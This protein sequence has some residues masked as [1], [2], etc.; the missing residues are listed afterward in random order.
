V[1]SGSPS[2]SRISCENS[3]RSQN[4]RRGGSGCKT[5]APDAHMSRSSALSPACVMRPAMTLSNNH[6]AGGLGAAYDLYP[7][8]VVGMIRLDEFVYLPSWNDSTLRH[9]CARESKSSGES[10]STKALQSGNSNTVQ[11][12]TVCVFPL[13][14]TIEDSW[15]KNN[16]ENH[17]VRGSGSSVGIT[18]DSPHGSLVNSHRPSPWSSAI[19]HIQVWTSGGFRTW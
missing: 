7:N 14:D 18:I 15:Q 11:R 10:L 16:V 12:N 9:R 17:L 13:I 1:I 5:L 19:K 3:N 4:H 6:V 8:Q 2:R